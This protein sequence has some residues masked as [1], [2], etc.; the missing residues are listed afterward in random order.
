L[1][2]GV[3]LLCAVL[4]FILLCVKAKNRSDESDQEMIAVEDDEQIQNVTTV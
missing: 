3:L 4:P 1:A 2:G